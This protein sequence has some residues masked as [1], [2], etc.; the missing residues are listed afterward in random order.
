MLTDWGQMLRGLFAL[1]F[2][3]ANRLII[4]T[5]LPFAASYLQPNLY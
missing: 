4:F 5:V 3:P 2:R 1:A